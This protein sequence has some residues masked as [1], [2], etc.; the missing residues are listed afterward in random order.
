LLPLL[1]LYIH[2]NS[3]NSLLL[4]VYRPGS[5]SPTVEFIDEI[6]DVLDRSS[7]YSKCIM[8]GDVNIHLD[9]PEA[10]QSTSFRKM[11]DDFGLSEWVKQPTHS[12]GHQLDVFITR[13]SQPISV[14]Q[15]DPPLL[16]SDHSLIT[17]SFSVLVQGVAAR[18]PRVLR[19]CWKHFDVDAFTVDFLASDLV[20][21]PPVEVTQLFNLYN[22][23]LKQ[24]VDK[25]VPVV[26]VTNYSRPKSPWFDR[27]C[28]VMKTKT[29][30]LEKIHRRQRT[31]ATTYRS[32]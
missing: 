10:P 2:G 24:L 26:T 5:K 1:P 31:G 30:R 6:T 9:D 29:R 13:V 3:M 15:V 8:V 21:C 7:S 25:H 14:V 22:N 27:D 16:I 32:V 18:R 12:Q 23:T 20:V 17:A 28:N 19:R 4:A 11:L